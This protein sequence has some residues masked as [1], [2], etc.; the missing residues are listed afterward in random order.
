MPK[1]KKYSRP[2]R[3]PTASKV[4]PLSRRTNLGEEPQKPFW[5]V[6]PSPPFSPPRIGS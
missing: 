3:K 2:G 5:L 6:L 1:S 4:R